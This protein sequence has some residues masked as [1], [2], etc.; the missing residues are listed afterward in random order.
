MAAAVSSLLDDEAECEETHTD[1]FAVC[2]DPQL[3]FS[4]ASFRF[5][6]FSGYCMSKTLK[7][8]YNLLVNIIFSQLRKPP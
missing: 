4:V 6:L 2:S 5:T 7:L 1:D 3:L 8:K